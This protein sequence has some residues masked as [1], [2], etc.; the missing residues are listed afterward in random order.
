MNYLH[1]TLIALFG[2]GLWGFG[3]KLSTR[4][5]PTS[6]NVFFTSAFSLVMLAG[7][8]AATRGFVWNRYV[9]LT[10]PVAVLGTVALVAFYRALE[11]GPG[12]VVIP[13]SGLYIVIPAILGFLFLHE[14]ITV[15][16]VIGILLAVASIIL[17]SR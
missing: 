6:A 10:V 16:K 17:L 12:S 7:L 11:K 9:W 8:L 2:W 13:L 1:W 4:Y 14:K 5:L 3:V 15:S